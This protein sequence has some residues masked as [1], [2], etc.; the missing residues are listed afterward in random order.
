MTSSTALWL[1]VDDS[2]TEN[3]CLRVVPRSHLEELHG[4]R[5]R[6]DVDSVLGSEIEV[7]VDESQ[8]ADMQMTRGSVEVHHPNIIHGSNANTSPNRRCGLTIRYI[9]T[10]TRILGDAGASA[11]HLRGELGVND[12]QPKPVYVPG[13]SF[14]FAGSDAW[15]AR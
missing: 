15:L 5:D 1:A 4:L 13:Q 8:A 11:I 10:S 3:G 14:P 12:Y 6:G 9:P 7:D 2:S